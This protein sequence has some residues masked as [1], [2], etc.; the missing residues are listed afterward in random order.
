VAKAP[1]DPTAYI[2]VILLSGIVVSNSIL[3]VDHINL[4]RRQGLGLLEAVVRGTK[5]RVRPIFMTTSTTIFGMLPLL[6]IGA[7]ANK[8]QIW[9]SLALCTVGGLT[10]STILVFVVIP[11]LYYHG[12]GL[13]AWGAEKAREA[14]GLFGKKKS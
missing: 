6:L 9:S 13:R 14:R 2:G 1:F 10:S 4:R 11:V 3:L 8:R 5:D 7:E 12:D